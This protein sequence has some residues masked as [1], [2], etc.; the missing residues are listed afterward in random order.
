MKCCSKSLLF[1][2]DRNIL[3]VYQCHQDHLY[4]PPVNFSVTGR[5]SDG[6][7][8]AIEDLE[9]LRFGVQFHPENS[10][11]GHIVLD[12]FLDLCEAK[13]I[14]DE[15]QSVNIKTSQY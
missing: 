6:I 3:R 8:Q 5:N 2:G 9:R 12:N 1:K 11:D 15:D 14:S 13:G 7:I 10:P 4:N